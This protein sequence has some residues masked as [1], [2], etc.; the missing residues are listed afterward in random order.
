MLICFLSITRALDIDISRGS[1]G[2][3]HN[4]TGWIVNQ[5]NTSLVVPDH[6]DIFI[7]GKTYYYDL[8]VNLDKNSNLT[9]YF[10]QVEIFLSNSSNGNCITI[11][12]EGYIEMIVTSDL[13]V[14]SD[15]GTALYFGE[16][17]K[18]T[19]RSEFDD[20]R[21]SLNC[22]SKKHGAGIGGLGELYIKGL[23]VEA[24]SD[25]SAAIGGINGVGNPKLIHIEG[26]FVSVIAGSLDE[27]SLGAAI[28]GGG[29]ADNSNL[30]IIINNSNV[31]AQVSKNSISAAIGGGGSSGSFTEGNFG[32]IF[33]INSNVKAYA[34]KR[35]T[36]DLPK[37]AYLYGTGAGIGGGSYMTYDISNIDKYVQSGSIYIENSAVGAE[38]GNSTVLGMISGSGIGFGG[39]VNKQE[40]HINITINNSR[41]KAFGGNTNISYAAAGIG[42]CVNQNH[43][44]FEIIIN[45]SEIT[46]VAGYQPY[47]TNQIACSIGPSSY[48]ISSQPQSS[49]YLNDCEGYIYQVYY[50]SIANGIEAK[51]IVINNSQLAFNISGKP[52]HSVSSIHIDMPTVDLHIPNNDIETI[53]FNSLYN[54]TI[55]ESGFNHMIISLPETGKY[56]ISAKKFNGDKC[57]FVSNDEAFFS[58]PGMEQIYLINDIDCIIQASN[59]KQDPT[60]FKLVL[61]IVIS[62]GLGIGLIGGIIVTIILVRKRKFERLVMAENNLEQGLMNNQGDV[63]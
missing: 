50:K 28:G 46:A 43:S 16:G 59:E 31:E 25:K 53:I 14:K 42:G 63:L 2:I 55:K 56:S 52:I 38:G 49:I 51:S 6:D 7:T 32:T 21:Y 41:V 57:S 18:V 22:Y 15:Y 11:D 12:G 47:K 17:T 40:N 61:I 36:F 33:V 44:S 5:A 27:I 20:F 60:G 19:I 34:S 54:Y 9:I 4:K 62:C 10:D 29:N 30:K 35:F 26:C 45:N 37:D 24:K 8:H 3:E 39:F 13:K 1:I 48:N 23:V 58:V